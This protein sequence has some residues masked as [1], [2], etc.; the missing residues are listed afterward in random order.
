MGL[1]IHPSSCCDVCLE[2]LTYDEPKPPYAIPCGHIFCKDCLH[3]INPR[4]CPLCRKAFLPER[5]KKLITGELP[6][7]EANEVELLKRLSISWDLPEEQLVAIT[8]EVEAWLHGQE[9]T[10]TL[11]P[12]RKAWEAL[13]MYHRLKTQT[14][15][16]RRTIRHLKRE[17]RATID[18]KNTANA[19][20]Q[21][22]IAQAE[23]LH[24]KVSLYESQ[25]KKLREELAKFRYTKNPL[26]APPEPVSLDRV[27]TLAQTAVPGSS[28]YL[29]PPT[30]LVNADESYYN[31]LSEGEDSHFHSREPGERVRNRKGKGK[32]RDDRERPAYEIYRSADFVPRSNTMV[33]G[34]TATFINGNRNAIIPGAAPDQRVVPMRKTAFEDYATQMTTGIITPPDMGDNLPDLLDPQKYVDPYT[35]TGEFVSAYPDGYMAGYQA[36]LN[37]RSYQVWGT[38]TTQSPLLDPTLGPHNRSSQ[39]RQWLS[40]WMAEG[41]RDGYLADSHRSVPPSSAPPHLESGKTQDAA[42]EYARAQ[43][44]PSPSSA[45]VLTPRA[46]GPSV[47]DGIRPLWDGR[48]RSTSQQIQPTTSATSSSATSSSITSA[49]R[50]DILYEN[51]R[52]GSHRRRTVR[53]HGNMTEPEVPA[54][55]ESIGASLRR[56]SAMSARHDGAVAVVEERASPGVD[57]RNSIS[58]WGTVDSENP[59]ISVS[60][61]PVHTDFS[62][63]AMGSTH[64]VS[65]PAHYDLSLNGRMSGRENEEE[66]VTVDRTVGAIATPR[67]RIASLS[68]SVRPVSASSHM[69]ERPRDRRVASSETLVHNSRYVTT[70]P[71]AQRQTANAV[72][73]YGINHASFGPL[74]VSPPVDGSS[75]NNNIT[76]REATLWT[77]ASHARSDSP[78][79]G[80]NALGLHLSRSPDN[81]LGL[82]LNRSPQISAPTPLFSG[83]AFLRAFSHDNYY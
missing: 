32:A 54:S 14:D 81:A 2:L 47:I 4:I 73:S 40:G 70:V 69:T 51:N 53:N 24:K 28:S 55:D 80:G 20:G 30:D 9:E 21:S 48:S 18:E 50:L 68:E 57:T 27:P 19:V 23:E 3:T 26:P 41:N 67:T 83:Q 66:T 76:S 65:S 12:L 43:R 58:S 33:N 1:I 6:P 36:A 59:P 74:P 56:R 37:P 35:L 42:P 31:H 79:L 63:G 78:S 71:P 64:S 7:Q 72:L 60:D 25:I 5:S 29:W 77:A 11:L 45:P 16:D 38:G 13:R 17:I 15:D 10:P 52:P 75:E 44:I 49:Q 22:V 61:L 82:R 8:T 62:R 39:N 34:M 46:P